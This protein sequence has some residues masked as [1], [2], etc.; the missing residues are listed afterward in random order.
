MLTEEEYW[1]QRRKVRK[2]CQEIAVVI[3][4]LMGF[5]GLLFMVHLLEEMK[6]EVRSWVKVHHMMS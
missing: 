1:E 2:C 5:L 6:E 4:T 3:F